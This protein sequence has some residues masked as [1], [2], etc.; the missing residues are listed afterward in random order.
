MGHFRKTDDKKGT[1]FLSGAI[2]NHSRNR[3]KTNNHHH[4]SNQLLLHSIGNNP[5]VIQREPAPESEEEII[6]G[7]TIDIIYTDVPPE[8]GLPEACSVE[9]SKKG[10][11]KKMGGPL[12]DVKESST[13]P[14]KVSEECKS[15]TKLNR[16]TYPTDPSA[17]ADKVEKHSQKIYKNYANG[18]SISNPGDFNKKLKEATKNPCFCIENLQID[19]HGG[20][21]SG[22]AQEFAP[23]KHSFSKRSF[24]VTRKDGK[25]IPYNLEIFDGIKFCKPCNIKLGGCYVALNKPHATAGASGYKNAFNDLGKFLIKKTGCSVTAHTSTTTTPK[26]GE[27]KG[28]AGG[29]WKTIQPKND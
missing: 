3:T 22:G 28:D 23:R 13:E 12:G 2:H 19:G 5:N 18:V 4:I 21:W 26:A 25:T 7:N 20:S 9:A 1:R 16:T 6:F 10:S 29:E 27:F 8:K 17:T 15:W 24:G 14:T 11:K